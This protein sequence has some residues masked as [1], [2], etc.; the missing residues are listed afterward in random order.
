MEFI[1]VCLFLSYMINTLLSSQLL[2][3]CNVILTFALCVSKLFFGLIVYNMLVCACSW[4]RPEIRASVST[5]NQSLVWSV[6]WGASKVREWEV[7]SIPI[8]S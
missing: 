2:A 1:V 8:L 6:I 3:L 5:C 4:H 7:P